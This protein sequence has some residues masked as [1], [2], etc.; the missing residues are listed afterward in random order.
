MKTK[1]ATREIPGKKCVGCGRSAT[2]TCSQC[3]RP[4]CRRAVGLC[5]HVEGICAGCVEKRFVALSR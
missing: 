5:G 2:A 3:G 4:T 1:K